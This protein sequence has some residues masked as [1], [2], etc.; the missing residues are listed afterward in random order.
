MAT[1]RLYIDQAR[2][3]ARSSVPAAEVFRLHD[4]Y[5]FPYEMTSE[6]L[7]QEDLSIEGDFEGLMEE[8]RAR[9]RASARAG[10]SAA[11]QVREAASSFAG[12][13]GVSTRFTGYETE[14]QQT[15]MAAV[16]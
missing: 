6:L 3:A 13:A 1:L 16:Q 14:R 8:Q 11:Q 12:E 7:A 15:T 2:D 5:G 9:G 10:G 4:T